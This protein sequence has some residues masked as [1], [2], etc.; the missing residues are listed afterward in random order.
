MTKV[1]LD[2][3][4]E[5]ESK[6]MPA[7]WSDEL[8]RRIIFGIA[9]DDGELLIAARNALPALIAELRAARAVVEV[10]RVAFGLRNVPGYAGDSMLDVGNRLAAYDATVQP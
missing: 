7:P 8:Y 3:L 6:A 9:K 1:D 10:A 2:A 4:A 5:L